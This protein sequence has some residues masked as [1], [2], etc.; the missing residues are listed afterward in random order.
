MKKIDVKDLSSDD[1]DEW[2]QRGVLKEDFSTKNDWDVTVYPNPS[3]GQIT[4][5]L[6]EESN[7]NTQLEMY[8]VDGS[9]VFSHLIALSDSRNSEVIDLPEL[10]PGMYIMEL[11][12][13]ERVKDKKI[14][15]Q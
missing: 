15:I 1:L 11:T 4:I 12:Q 2:K 10:E 14:I 9:K 13:G 8:G 6:K 7:Q 5:D 3:N